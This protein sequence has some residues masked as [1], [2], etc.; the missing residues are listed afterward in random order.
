[1]INT[2]RQKIYIKRNIIITI[3]LMMVIF[4]MLTGC[5]VKGDN[6]SETKVT[7]NTNENNNTSNV[8]ACH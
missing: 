5:D 3:F 8:P 7:T 1:M 6:V 2:N 4:L